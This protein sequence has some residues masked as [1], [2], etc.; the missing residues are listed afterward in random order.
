VRSPRRF[1]T[2]RNHLGG[3]CM[4]E[5]TLRLVLPI[6][7]KRT[8]TPRRKANTA[9]RP[10]EHL[11]EA[12]VGRLIKVAKKN[13]WGLPDSAM[14]LI[15]CR[16][17]LRVSE[18]VNLQWAAVEFESATLHVGRSKGGAEGTHYLA[19]DEMRALRAL[20]RESQGAFLF[21]SERGAPLSVSG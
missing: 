15:A 3:I 19:G 20:R 9:Y 1:Q 4:A 7:E 12:E 5:T 21:V 6:G 11:T 16:H 17:G 18:L 8:V 13:R 14:I 10:R 2:V